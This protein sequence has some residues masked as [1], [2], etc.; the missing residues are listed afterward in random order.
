[1]VL[2]CTIYY[3]LLM[4]LY[5]RKPSTGNCL[6]Q[7]DL[8]LLQSNASYVIVN[9]MFALFQ[10]MQRGCLAKLL[11]CKLNIV[12]GMGHDEII[13]PFVSIFCFLGILQLDQLATIGTRNVD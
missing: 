13:L 9:D 7:L 4:A 5:S 6:N 11:F 2:C 8:N 1:M 10:W 12:D 3:Q